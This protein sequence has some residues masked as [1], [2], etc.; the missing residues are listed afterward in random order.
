MSALFWLGAALLLALAL[1]F[2]LPPLWRGRG[3]TGAQ[4]AGA[5]VAV[6]RDQLAE[7][8]RDLAA[9][10]ITQ[11][12]FDQLKAEIQRRVLEDTA[13]A[14]ASQA[15]SAAAG[16][17]S[18]RTAW[19]L[20]LV[21]P[22]A[23][24]A[25]YLALGRPDAARPVAAAEAAAEHQVTAEQI[26]AMVQT[27][28]DRL[29]AK[30][31][32]VEGWQ[33][34]ARSYAAMGRPT[35]AVAALRQVVTLKPGDAG[36][37]AD[38]A[39]MLTMAQDRRFD[40]EPQR[41]IDQALA[42]DAQHPKALAL[43]GSAA[44]DRNDFAA[45]QALWQRLLAGLPADSELAQQVRGGIAEAQQRQA[46][47]GAGAGAGPGAGVA[48]PQAAGTA[49]SAAA[50]SA[51]T[52]ATAAG[53]R[54]QVSVSPQLLAQVPAG[55]TLFVFARAAQGSRMPLAIV[56]QPVP[57]AGGWP[58][59][60]TLD[61]STSM[62]AGASLSQAGQVVVVAR[63]SKSGNATPQSGDLFGESAPL[64]TNA[65]GLQLVIDRVQP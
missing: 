14:P 3:A 58:L 7:A 32:D 13:A 4:A 45:A 22:L 28:A 46:A 2:V 23:S 19:V 54:G 35:D 51:P 42:L 37:L 16:Q 47:A 6:Y 38:L 41:L 57:A 40:G 61:D 9:D 52:A 17:P 21:L 36:V 43:A 8:E 12:R 49:P 60:F 15:A 62:A 10:L 33:M 53:L 26:Q 31:D 20:L 48:P 29:K 50:A 44:F 27:L 24:V 18:R 1:A 55:A 5:N 63:I 56:R 25:T 30:P 59:A 65:Q 39:D 34:L 11:D 64:A